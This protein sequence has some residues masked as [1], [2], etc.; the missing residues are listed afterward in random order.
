[1]KLESQRKKWLCDS[2]SGVS[3]HAVNVSYISDRV[4]TLRQEIRE[5]RDLSA[6]YRSQPE[7]TQADQSAY[8]FQQLRLLHLKHELCDLLKHDFRMR[9]EGDATG[10]RPEVEGKTA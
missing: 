1:M 7:H 3:L 2:Q 9:A 5:L 8:E 6:R 10:S 4:T